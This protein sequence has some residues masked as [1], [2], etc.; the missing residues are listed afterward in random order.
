MAHDRAV[1]SQG[2]TLVHE[3]ATVSSI[4]GDEQQ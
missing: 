1:L 2:P 3:R 4:W